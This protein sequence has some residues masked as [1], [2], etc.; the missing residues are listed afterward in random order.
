MREVLSAGY[1][2]FSRFHREIILAFSWIPLFFLACLPGHGE[3]E[4]VTVGSRQD[5][6][7]GMVNALDAPGGEHLPR[8]TVSVQR[9]AVEQEDAVG[10]LAG[11]VQ[12]VN[13][14]DD[15]DRALAVEA[16]REVEDTRLVGDV[17]IGGRLVEK[18]YGGLLGDGAGDGSELSFT[19]AERIDGRVGGHLQAGHARALAGDGDLLAGLE[20]TG[21]R[22]MRETP[23]EEVVLQG[24]GADVGG[25]VHDG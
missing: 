17:E 9:A 18:E 22:T 14:Q 2:A 1:P 6:H 11:K 15:G 21:A 16:S 24:D 8:G 13:D 10:V 4:R 5:V 7:A 20:K 3:D 25:L 23:Q 12:V 19:T